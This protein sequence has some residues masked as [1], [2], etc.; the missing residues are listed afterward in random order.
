MLFS[1]AN[2]GEAK[3]M[4]PRFRVAAGTI[5]VA[6]A[7]S[8]VLAI[9]LVSHQRSS[10]PGQANSGAAAG[11]ATASPSTVATSASLTTSSAAAT[12][13]TPSPTG[14]PTPTA[15]P[16][17][18]LAASDAGRTVTVPVGATLQIDLAAFPPSTDPSIP[19]GGW[20]PLVSRSTAVV[21]E[22]SSTSDTAGAAHGVFRA[23]TAGNSDVYSTTH[24]LPRQGTP[25]PC[26]YM[27][28]RYEV[29]IV[30]TPQ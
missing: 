29:H 3:P 24:C 15:A 2:R 12:A 23:A 11:V 7:L 27:G 19:S 5:L 17:V 21:S 6:S 8:A 1:A 13:A 18:H 26:P 28:A 4:L 10:G 16:I 22:V 9:A 14:Q 25:A 20:G 30:V